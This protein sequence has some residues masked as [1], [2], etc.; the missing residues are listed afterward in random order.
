MR[1]SNQKSY[2]KRQKKKQDS[3]G[4]GSNSHHYR[5]NF[6]RN[7]ARA[8][9]KK[10]PLCVMCLELELTR[11]A[12]VTDHIDPVPPNADKEMFRRYSVEENLQGLCHSHHQQKT[13]YEQDK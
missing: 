7:T 5:S 2:I 12:D 11:A 3:K 13:R 6:W 1:R 10:N 8:H 4:W 9:K